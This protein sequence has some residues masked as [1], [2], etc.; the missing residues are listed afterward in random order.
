VGTSPLQPGRDVSRGAVKLEAAIAA[1]A[2]QPE[3]MVCADL[4][5][6]VGG[7]VQ[8]LLRHGAARVYSVDTGYG[9][10]DY[11]LRKNDRVVV[12]E[13]TNALHVVLPEPLDL[14]TI[15]VGW[16]RQRHILPAALRMLKPDGRILSLVK[17][18]YEAP[19]EWLRRGVL[20]PEKVPAVVTT[21][22]SS[23]HELGVECLGQIDSPIPGHSGNREVLFYLRRE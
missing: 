20:P 9:V 17:P 13:R 10:F 1:F 23:L 11:T 4:G 7:F 19:R 5:S 3:G 15:D 18:H 6:N 16:T 21:V 12:M 2:V 8:C 22:R 14:V